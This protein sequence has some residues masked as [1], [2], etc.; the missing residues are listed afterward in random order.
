MKNLKN[1]LIALI[2]IVGFLQ[3]CSD[4]L[5]QTNPNEVSTDTYYSNLEQS[6]ASLTGVYGGM[7]DTFIVNPWMESLR[8]DLGIISA[9]RTNNPNPNARVIPYYTHTYNPGSFNFHRQWNALYQVIFRANQL[10]EGL[11]SMDDT[12]KS[13]EIWTEQMGQA[14]LLRGM[15]HF[16]LHAIYNKGEIIIRDKV[17]ASTE[18]ISKP[19]STSAEVIEFFRDDLL[20]AYNNL[21]HAFDQKT[22]V[23]KGLAATILGTSHLYEKE[24]NLAIGYFDDIINNKSEYGYALL[25]GENVKLMYTSAG[26]FNS[27]SIFEINYSVELKGNESQWYEESFSNRNARYSAPNSKGGGAPEHT[28]VAAWLTEAYSTEFLDP[29]DVRN[30]VIGHN[31]RD[32]ITD[33]I[34]LRASSMVSLVNDEH[35]EYYQKPTAAIADNFRNNK[36]SLF[37]Q[38]TNHDITDHEKNVG[39]SPWQS[40]K[41]VIINRFADV[42]LM[43]AECYLETGRIT[44]ALGDIN[45]IRERWGLALL[46]PVVNASKTYIANEPVSNLPY[47][48]E[49]TLR[50]HLRHVE[51]PLELNIQ[52]ISSRNIDLRRWGNAKAR[53][54]E[55]SG[56]KYYVTDY[57][58]VDEAG[59]TKKRAK[60][61]LTRTVTAN[62][63][64]IN[65]ENEFE[66]AAQNYNDT[67]D[68]LPIPLSESDNNT[69]I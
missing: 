29:L 57:T 4:Y 14:R 60:S 15:C 5:D 56:I 16:Y 49:N 48:D 52:G 43:R 21:P 66:A 47:T 30:T 13:N 64:Y 37:K 31:G 36:I 17:P 11:E 51:R 33:N 38:H 26:D 69:S 6:D 20:Y 27:E 42:Y 24:Y 12:L 41:N 28:V 58:Y 44:E 40:G 7:L 19:T 18:E 59:K 50:R 54:A 9:R 63:L 61:L 10:I 45:T 1:K 22:R 23:D 67:R 3:S 25:T 2:V 39:V 68:Y 53:F 8:S 34:S 62:E 32:R 65:G 46:G 35:T 55:L